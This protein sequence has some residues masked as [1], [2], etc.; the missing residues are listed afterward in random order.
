MPNIRHTNKKHLAHLEIVRRQDKAIRIGA[1]VIILL[2]IGIVVYGILSNTVLLP[3]RSV[4]SVNG[5]KISA[6]EF[7]SQVKVQRIQSINRYMQYLQYAQML[8]IQNPLQ[9]TNFGPALQQELTRL[10]TTSVMGQEVIDQMIDTVLIRQDAKKLGI[11]INPEEIDK[12]L[13]ESFSYFPNGTPTVAPTATSFVT[14]TLNP[15]ALAIVTITPIPTLVPTST[16]DVNITP[17]ATVASAPTAT[18]GPTATSRPTATPVSADGYATLLKERLD[19]IKKD[20]NLDEAA[21]RILIED[22]LLRTKLAEEV[23]KDVS[24]DSEEIWARHILVNTKEEADK[25]IARLRAGEDFAAVSSEVS[26]DTGAK[27]VGGDLGW[28]GKG[29]MVAPFEEAAFALPVGQISE[30]VQ[31]DFGFHVIQVIDHRSRPATADELTTA[32]QKAFTDYLKK[33]RDNSKVETYDLWKTIVP[34]EPAL[35]SNVQQ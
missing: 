12:T 31:T 9:D 20:T 1:I 32:K 3:L 30:P 19:G 15:T 14:P 23:T 26:I 13:Q 22:S 6:G 21:Y 29:A 11:T 24:T 35:P 16:P 7:Q 2:V 33:L 8:G 4:A 5:E 28:F 10:T 25:V 18:A 27:A 34:T 17:T